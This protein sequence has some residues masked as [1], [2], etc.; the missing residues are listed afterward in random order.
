MNIKEMLNSDDIET[1]T[2][3]ANILIK[4]MSTNDLTLLLDKEGK[5][6]LWSKNGDEV[7]LNYTPKY[8]LTKKPIK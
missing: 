2:L 7:S 3:A 1:A 5:Y 8:L 6:K 4:E